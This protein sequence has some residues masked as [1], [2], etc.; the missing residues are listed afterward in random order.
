MPV[1]QHG[2]WVRRGYSGNIG[3][4]AG[5]VTSDEGD[6]LRISPFISFE[7]GLRAGYTPS[8]SSVHG[9]AIAFQL[10]LY[11]LLTTGDPDDGAFG[12]LRFANIDGYITG[13]QVQNLNTAVGF[14]V[15]EFHFMPYVQFGQVD[16]WYFSAALMKFREEAGWILA[17]SYTSMKKNSRTISTH[18]TYTL[19]MGNVADETLIM[20]GVSLI[21]EFYR[22]RP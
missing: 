22:A 15:S 5:G 14:T 10:P 17:P 19:G 9:A 12:F 8:D 18:A 21:F 4:G 3:G 1:V 11:S 6:G 13:P 2:P 16:D 7:G 20:A